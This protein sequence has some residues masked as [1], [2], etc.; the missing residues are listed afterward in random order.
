MDEGQGDLGALPEMLALS[1]SGDRD[2]RDAFREMLTREEWAVAMAPFPQRT[3]YHAANLAA[4]NWDVTLVGERL[5]ITCPWSGGQWIDHAGQ[6][7]EI[8]DAEYNQFYPRIHKDLTTPEGR[9]KWNAGSTGYDNTKRQRTMVRAKT[10]A[11]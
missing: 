3:R 9:G 2:D 8:T 11:R 1:S 7:T 5:L 10:G 4:H 6:F